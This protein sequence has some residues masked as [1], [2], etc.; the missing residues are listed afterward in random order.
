MSK[1][2]NEHIETDE[3]SQAR[4]CELLRPLQQSSG[5]AY[6]I[7][8]KRAVELDK[9]FRSLASSYSALYSQ[10][11]NLE[12]KLKASKEQFSDKDPDIL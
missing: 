4:I 10:V 8:S 11:L 3:V 1:S 5:E 12:K 7:E 9:R 2:D 6:I